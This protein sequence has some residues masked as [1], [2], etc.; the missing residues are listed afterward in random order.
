MKH[1]LDRRVAREL[2]IS[3]RKVSQITTEFL[4]QTSLMLAEHGV[5][6]LDGFGNFIVR[7][8]LTN[9]TAPLV[10]GHFK[11]GYRGKTRNVVVR[12]YLQVHF[13][14]ALKLKKLLNEQYKESDMEKYGVDENTGTNQEQLEKQAAKG[15][16]ECGSE[17]TKHGSVL[18]CPKHGSAPFEQPQEDGHG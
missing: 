7:K 4:H 10:T 18:L 1:E 9:R 3:H 11:K 12:S 14:K 2:R 15:C 6:V 17:L 8:V 16:P 13:S 5:A